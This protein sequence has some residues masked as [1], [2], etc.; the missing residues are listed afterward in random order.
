MLASRYLRQSLSRAA[1]QNLRFA[2]SLIIAEHDGA[3]VSGSSLSS[4]TAASQLGGE[5]HLLLCGSGAPSAAAHAASLPGV[6]KVLVAGD[7]AYDHGLAENVSALVAAVQQQGGYSHVLAT[8]S[9]FSLNFVPRL[10][11]KLDVAPVTDVMQIHG[12]DTFTRP[13]Y[14]GNALA[15]IRSSDA[16]K[17]LLIRGTSFE[18]CAEEGGDAVVEEVAAADAADAGLSSFVSEAKSSSERPEL[19]S[20]RVVVSGGRGM[21][22][23]DNFAMLEQ[24]ADKLG[25]AVGASRAAVDAG[26][27]PNELQVGQTGKV[28]AP[29]LYIAVGISGAIQHLSG[30]KDSKTIVAINKDAEAP[31]FQVADYGLVQ[32]LFDVVPEM[33]EKVA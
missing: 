10:A 19:G 11:A 23:G 16:V 17:V 30:M 1:T 21:K 32:D 14:A 29:D 27:V 4:V 9:N 3:Q 15:R 2:S 33:T 13:M 7:A 18:K 24:L 22:S 26:F 31:I 5:A 6:S 25:G 20:A 28:V 8:T 12:E